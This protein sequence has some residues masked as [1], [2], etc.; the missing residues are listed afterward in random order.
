EQV[1]AGRCWR[2]DS[3]VTP[4]EIEGWFFKITAYAEELLAWCDRLPG[5][6]ERVLTMQRNWIGKSEG[7]E[8][9]LP[10][11]G[12]PR[13]R[14]DAPLRI[15]VFTTRPDTSFGMTYVVL[16]PEHP[17]VDRLLVDDAER[18]RVAGFRA[19]V[20]RESEI[21]R[22][23]ADRPKRGLRLTARA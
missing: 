10:V 20:A 16:A 17:L 6:P 9:D 7:A 1:E 13:G 12:A 19:E 22:L 14:N 11:E 3:E 15:R 18:E 8:V 2:C 21:E 5:W 23:A 4:R